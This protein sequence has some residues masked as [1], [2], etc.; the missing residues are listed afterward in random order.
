M[1]MF[2]SHS[3][4]GSNYEALGCKEKP[5]VYDIMQKTETAEG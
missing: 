5:N 3:S 2:Y 4:N 1:K